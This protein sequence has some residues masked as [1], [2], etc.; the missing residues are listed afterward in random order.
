ML[1]VAST[2]RSDFRGAK[3][4]EPAKT[5]DGIR[6]N[7]LIGLGITAALVGG[8][9][10]WAG[11]SSLAGAVIAGGTVVVE[12]A[13]KKVQ[14]QTGGVVGEILVKN[15]D[16]VEAGQILMKLDETM[17]RANLQIVSQQLDRADARMARLEGERIGASEMKI[18]VRL[19][20]RVNEPE[21]AELL[22]GERA[23]FE[24]RMTFIKGQ[25]AQLGERLG[26]YAQQIEGLKAQQ[27]SVEDSLAL[28]QDDFKTVG[29][30]YKQKLVSLDRISALRQNI[31]RLEGE[32]GRLLAAVAETEGRIS[33]TKLQII[34]IGEDQRREANTDLRETEGRQVELLERKLVAEDQLKRTT[35]TAPQSGF[36]QQI[37]IQTVG[38]VINPGET[39]MSIVPQSDALV[40][41]ARISP[42]SVDD[43]VPGQPVRIRFSAFDRSTTPECD[44]TVERVS[45]DLVH[46]QQQQ[47][48]YYE[49]RIDVDD[50]ANCLQGARRLLPGMPAEVYIQTGERGVWSY[51]MK[52]LT[53]QLTRAFK[54]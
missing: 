13:V 10:V 6:H 41:D 44:G 23:L 22:A 4:L 11:S 17:T 5:N 12:T 8:L 1:D 54:E 51:L 21:I 49:V 35:I 42:V 18:P 50:Q 52:P 19:A 43:V 34:Q 46:D 26:Q 30:L 40:I 20:A 14:H 48:S 36:V 39:I 37:A 16:R 38:G 25:Q 3:K 24:S 29:D 33:E 7:V 15:G 53:D 47:I 27:K 31:V 28:T 2:N 9:G 45:A 32:A